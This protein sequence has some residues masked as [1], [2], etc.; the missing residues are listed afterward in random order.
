MTQ[1][2]LQNI[3]ELIIKKNGLLVKKKNMEFKKQQ[4]NRWYE[5]GIK[6]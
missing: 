5:K 6:T 3:K 1:K 4:K 2:G